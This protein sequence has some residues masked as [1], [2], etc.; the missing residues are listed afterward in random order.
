MIDG[1]KIRALRDKRRWT[2]SDLEQSSGVDQGIISNLENDRKEGTRIETL[3]ALAR[4]LQVATDDLLVPAKPIPIEPTDPQLDVM[5]R[6]VE[7]MT[8]AERES[9]ETFMR[10][11]ISRRKRGKPRVRHR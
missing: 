2:Q 9:A 11:V 4:A 10:F 7:D 6:L 1:A 5:M 8:A 3:V